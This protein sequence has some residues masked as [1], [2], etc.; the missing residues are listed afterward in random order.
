MGI[1]IPEEELDLCHGL[2]NTAYLSLG[3]TNDL[4][5]WQKEYETAVAVGQDYVVNIISVLMEEHGI[6]E[7]EAKA[8]CREKI[9]ATVAECGK[10]VQDTNERSDV[11]V[12]LKKYLEALLYSISE[13]L[14]WSLESPRY[15]HWASYNERELDW[16]KNGSTET[17]KVILY[18]SRETGIESDS[19][20]TEGLNQ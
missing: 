7:E 14:V 5:S 4:V 11:S 8:I 17:D 19:C 3:L 10:I 20:V 2:A 9:K 1:S 13:N 12:E 15:H 18:Q 6:S 16:M